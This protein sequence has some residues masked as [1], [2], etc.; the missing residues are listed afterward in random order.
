MFYLSYSYS[1]DELSGIYS[2]V[3]NFLGNVYYLFGYFIFLVTIV[4][5]FDASWAY[6][7]YN[8]ATL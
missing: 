5:Y 8:E 6:F 4:Y 2:T 1:E 7:Y 3:E